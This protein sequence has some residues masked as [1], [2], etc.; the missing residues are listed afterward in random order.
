MSS[1]LVTPHATTAVSELQTE[2]AGRTV[3]IIS[4]VYVSSG[5]FEITVIFLTKR[6]RR[7]CLR[8]SKATTEL[9]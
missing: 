7:E 6:Q 8:S 1:Y 9:V 2:A 4:A 5:Y 3:F